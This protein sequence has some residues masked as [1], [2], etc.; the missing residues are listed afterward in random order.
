MKSTGRIDDGGINRL[1]VNGFGD[2]TRR[3]I[4]HRLSI[5][6]PNHHPDDP[7]SMETVQK[8]AEFLLS[9]TS[10]L[11]PATREFSS[12]VSGTSVSPEREI[13]AET[14]M[15]TDFSALVAAL[16]TSVATAV[17]K[18]LNPP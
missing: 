6:E 5:I 7:Y 4:E 16:S 9:A 3:R 18:A 12:T 10:S 11:I 14:P 17:A 15:P 13:K 2:A 1:F 8:A